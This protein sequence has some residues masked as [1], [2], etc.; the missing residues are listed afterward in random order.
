MVVGRCWNP[1]VSPN[2]VYVLE[3]ILEFLLWVNH[4]S[5]LNDHFYPPLKI[6]LLK[7]TLA[8]QNSQGRQTNSATVP[9][10]WLFFALPQIFTLKPCL[11][12]SLLSL[13]SR[14]YWLFWC[15]ASKWNW[16]L[17]PPI[18]ALA[19][20]Y[21]SSLTQLTWKK[22]SPMYLFWSSSLVWNIFEIYHNQPFCC[23]VVYWGFLST[24]QL[25]NNIKKISGSRIF[26]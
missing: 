24:F 3:T 20:L 16:L 9:W 23:V 8:L 13:A 26:F 15:L 21:Y 12:A 6:V 19:N 4:L 22:V 14:W 25:C 1:L 17:L 5:F 2:H 11:Q 18:G 7:Q 10:H